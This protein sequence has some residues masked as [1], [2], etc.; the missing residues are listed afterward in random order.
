MG[1]DSRGVPGQASLPCSVTVQNV[2]EGQSGDGA[3]RTTGGR[4]GGQGADGA[5]RGG[6]DPSGGTSPA[7]SPIPQLLSTTTAAQPSNPIHAVP[8]VGPSPVHNLSLSSSGS[9]ASLHASWAAASGQRDGYQLT[10]YHSDS[11]ALVR[12]ASVPPNATAFLFDGLAAGSEYALKVS[13]LSGASRASTSTH[14]WTGREGWVCLS[15]GE[16]LG[17]MKGLGRKG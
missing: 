9:P 8:H 13:T 1:L 4:A 12:N 15:W 5:V 7:E 16:G 17:G 6:L 2:P 10:L 3:A 11:Q 14:Q